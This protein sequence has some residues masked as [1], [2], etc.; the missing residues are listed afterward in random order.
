MSDL[1]RKPVVRITIENALHKFE[2]G[3]T[4]DAEIYMFGSWDIMTHATG[5]QACRF[6]KAYELLRPNE[7]KNPLM[8][9]AV[10]TWLKVLA[11]SYKQDSVNIKNKKRAA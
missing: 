5:K 10:R 3:K 2:T 7:R 4:T 6:Q 1:G 8:I 11:R 9:E